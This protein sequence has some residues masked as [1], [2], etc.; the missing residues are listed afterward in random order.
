MEAA[1]ANHCGAGP[2]PA[3]TTQARSCRGAAPC[4]WP[5]NTTAP[6]WV[7]G[8]PSKAGWGLQV[9]KAGLGSAGGAGVSRTGW[10]PTG[11]QHMGMHTHHAKHATHA[12]RHLRHHVTYT[13]QTMYAV[14]T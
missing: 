2:P 13:H 1:Q 7:R 9:P 12:T 14:Q 5:R 6:L 8:R 4:W 3:L 11:L 10:T